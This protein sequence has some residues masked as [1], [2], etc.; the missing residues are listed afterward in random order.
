MFCRTQ[1]I[2]VTSAE[3]TVEGLLP[4]TQYVFSIT[5]HNINGHSP[6][7]TNINIT[8][9]KFAQVPEAVTNMRVW[10]TSPYSVQVSWDM[11]SVAFGAITEFR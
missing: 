3:C 9:K 10:P 7:P 2:N 11:P 1:V 4:A 6:R 5:S 8:T